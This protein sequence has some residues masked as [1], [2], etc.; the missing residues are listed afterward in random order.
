MIKY[1]M[2]EASEW[3]DGKERRFFMIWATTIQI[4]WCTTIDSV[5][6]EEIGG[7]RD[8]HWNELWPR[9]MTKNYNQIY[10]N[11]GAIFKK[12]HSLAESVIGRGLGKITKQIEN[13]GATI[14]YWNG[15]RWGWE[16]K[17]R[18]FAKFQIIFLHRLKECGLFS[19][20]GTEGLRAGLL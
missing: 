14:E 8:R 15:H 12:I 20:W 17:D 5:E 16:R 4:L 1:S 13:G 7:S 18:K 11:L 10:D 9:E 6:E 19:W 3:M 2:S